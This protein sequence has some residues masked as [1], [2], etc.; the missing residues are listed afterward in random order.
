MKLSIESSEG[1]ML[2]KNRG[3]IRLVLL[4]LA[5]LR[6]IYIYAASPTEF[7]TPKA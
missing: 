2:Y 6:D 1:F 4:V 3:P 7:P 5:Q